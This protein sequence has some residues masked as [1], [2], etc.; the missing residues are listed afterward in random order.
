MSV[1]KY[2]AVADAYEKYN[3]YGTSELYQLLGWDDLV[4]RPEWANTCAL[5]NLQP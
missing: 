2:Q 1:I 3:A 5:P 4:G